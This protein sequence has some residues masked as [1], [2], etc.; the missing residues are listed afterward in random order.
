MDEYPQTNYVGYYCPP[1]YRH[2]RHV[3]GTG[4]KDWKGTG[5]VQYGPHHFNNFLSNNLGG[6][7]LTSCNCGEVFVECTPGTS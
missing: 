3:C 2:S 1:G 5:E 4:S 7:C 6:H